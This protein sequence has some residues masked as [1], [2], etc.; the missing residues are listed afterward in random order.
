MENLTEVLSKTS[1][2]KKFESEFFTGGEKKDLMRSYDL[3]TDDLEVLDFLQSENSKKMSTTNK[4]KLH[5]ETGKIYFNNNNT[6]ESIFYF[7]LKQ[8]DPTKRIIDHDFVYS[9]S[10]N[11]YFQWLVDGFDSQEKT[12]LDVLTSKN[13]KFFFYRMNEVLQANNLPLKKVK[14]GVVTEDYIA[15][16]KIQ[17]QNLQYFVES[18]LEACRRKNSGEKVY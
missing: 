4:L 1:D 14:H 18:A 12:K 2:E 15:I 8:Q 10:H 9:G 5:V 17:S 6:S 13:A 7:F 16:E 3:W 11:Y